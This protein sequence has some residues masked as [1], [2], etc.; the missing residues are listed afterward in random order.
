MK[1]RKIRGFTII[2]IMVVVFIIG[3][4]AS[5]IVPNL[6]GRTDEAKVIK[7]KQDIMVLENALEMYRLDNGFYPSTD[8]GLEALVEKA[9]IEPMPKIWR[10]GGYIKKLQQ[11]PWGRPYQYLNP[12]SHG[13]ID[14]F[15]LG[16]DGNPGGENQDADVGNW[17]S[18]E[19]K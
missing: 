10:Q 14:I 6:I 7:A 18:D 3:L 5:V 2:E 16:R 17:N 13:E 4:L 12:G 8:Q 1:K 11:D 15:S 19:K 9:N